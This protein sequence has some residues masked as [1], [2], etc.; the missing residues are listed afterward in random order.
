[1][2]YTVTEETNFCRIFE[3]PE[4]FPSGYCFGGGKSCTFQMVDWFNPC[5]EK[6]VDHDEL[7]E[8]LV[9][10]LSTKNYV[11]DGKK[12]LFLSDFGM[13]FVFDNKEKE[14]HE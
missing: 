11:K 4:R 6:T 9:D 14:A 2:K 13:S 5:T 8:S 1:M 3:L 7:K 10:F 12:Y